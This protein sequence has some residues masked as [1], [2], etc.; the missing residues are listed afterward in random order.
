MSY[1][2]HFYISSIYKFLGIFIS[3]FFSYNNNRDKIL[4]FQ[5][6]FNNLY[7]SCTFL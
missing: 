2:Y 6:I 5:E 3:L 7:C 4:I 1:N